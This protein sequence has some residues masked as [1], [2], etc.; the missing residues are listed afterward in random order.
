MCSWVCSAA[1]WAT[2]LA[3]AAGRAERHEAEGLLAFV[4]YR[5]ALGLPAADLPH[6]DR[7]LVEIARALATRPSVLLLDEPAAGLMRADKVLLTG[8]LR[9]LA[10]AGLAIV[11]VEH[12]MALVMGISDHHGGARCRP[13]DRRWRARRGARRGEGARRLPRHR[14]DRR[15]PARGPAAGRANAAA[16]RRGAKARAIARWPCSTPSLSRSGGANW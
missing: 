12:D 9:R 1:A 3:E 16:D 8:V 7:R 2:R 5:G 4:G 13:A 6:V 15:P 11:L 14:R 10:D